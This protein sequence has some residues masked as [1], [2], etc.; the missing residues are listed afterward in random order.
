M[1]LEA[2]ASPTCPNIQCNNAT[3][4]DLAIMH[5]NAAIIASLTHVRAA[6]A[7]TRTGVVSDLAGHVDRMTIEYVR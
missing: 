3:P 7:K 4:L 5:G 1:L 2:G 6:P